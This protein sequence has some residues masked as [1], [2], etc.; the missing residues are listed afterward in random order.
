ME[1]REIKEHLNSAFRAIDSGDGIQARFKLNGA[2]ALLRPHINDYA[3]IYT[4][5]SNIQST[6]FCLKK[7]GITRGSK[8]FL[9]TQI[10][11]VINECELWMK[12]AA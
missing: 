2:S 1:L 11:N 7:E 3:D 5:Y 6:L 8:V 9:L 4:A 12:V 10:N